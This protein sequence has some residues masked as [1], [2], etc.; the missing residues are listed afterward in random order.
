MRRYV[1][2]GVGEQLSQLPRIAAHDRTGSPP[3][4]HSLAEGHLFCPNHCFLSAAPALAVRCGPMPMVTSVSQMAA[5][6]VC[7]HPASVC[8]V[9][10]VL[11]VICR[12]VMTLGGQRR[13][14]AF[15][16]RGELQANCNEAR[17]VHPPWGQA[18]PQL[19]P[20]TGPD[21]WGSTL[22]N[23]DTIPL[24]VPRMSVS[25]S[26][27]GVAPRESPSHVLLPLLW[28][29]LS[30]LAP[31]LGEDGKSPTYQRGGVAKCA[32]GLQ[33]ARFSKGQKLTHSPAGE[34]K[35]A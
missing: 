33:N 30:V 15:Y 4:N 9:E 5:Y 22:P 21:P 12:D 14:V 18:C 16:S 8:L 7:S 2:V 25:V 26:L 35:H 31:F 10:H 1:C 11:H 20:L 23:R 28:R 29:P 32:K 34:E 3:D 13:A 27:P 17:C 6:R 19:G 24:S